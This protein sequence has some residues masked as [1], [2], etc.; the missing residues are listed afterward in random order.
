MNKSVSLEIEKQMISRM[1]IELG[2]SFT[3][4]LEAMFKD[5]ATSKDLTSGYKEY[6]SELGDTDPSRVDLKIDV[7]TSGTWPIEGMNT[8]TDDEVAL[9][10]NVAY[11]STVQRVIQ[12]FERFYAD[13]HS[14][15]KLSWQPN[16]GTVD[17]TIRFPNKP[18]AAKPFRQHEVNVPTSGMIVLML[19][20]DLPPDEHLTYADIKATTN[21]W[22]HELK[23]ILQSPVAKKTQILRKEPMSREVNEDDKFFFNEG[24]KSEYR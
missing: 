6:V 14:G 2:N 13:K 9:R 7:L 3:M 8:S 19:F 24:F 5:M 10:A 4:K 1:K 12:G 17:M 21:I 16:L 22:D 23:R 11:P 20:Q 15:R 18:G